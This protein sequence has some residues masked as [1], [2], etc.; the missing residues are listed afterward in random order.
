VETKANPNP[1]GCLAKALPTEPMFIL[2][3]R[4]RAAPATIRF[5]AD[6][7]AQ[8]GIEDGESQ[9]AEQLS[10]A[11]D[12]AEAFARWRAEN[13]GA[14][15]NHRP[16]P[17]C[18]PTPTDELASIAGRILARPALDAAAA[19]AGVPVSGEKFNSLLV[20]AKKLAGF[21]LHAD[22]VAGPNRE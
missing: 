7:R 16:D 14:W 19:E 22:P 17:D 2:L 15:R 10:E 5:W 11:I 21:V 20:D 1:N 9:D 8:L 4:D 6:Q 12:T 18:V 13:E 3:G